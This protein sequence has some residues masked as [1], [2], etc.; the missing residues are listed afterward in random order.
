LAGLPKTVLEN[1]Q[2]RAD[3]LK[4]ETQK[5]MMTALARRTQR[6][7][8]STFSNVTD[9]AATLRTAEWLYKAVKLVVKE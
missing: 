9:S 4:V 8:Q 2:L 6:L 7:L 5:R 3:C 1:A